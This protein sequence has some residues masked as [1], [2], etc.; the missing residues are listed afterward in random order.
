[1]INNLPTGRMQAIDTF[2]GLTVV[3]MLFFGTLYNNFDVPAWMSDVHT[4]S[5]T[6]TLADLI[7][8]AFLFVMGMAIP[9]SINR[10]I[11]SNENKWQIR[12]H[13]IGRTLALMVLG[14]FIANARHVD[15]W[16]TGMNKAVWPLLFFA[17]TLLILLDYKVKNNWLVRICRMIGI[18]GLIYLAVIFRGNDGWKAIVF[19]TKGPLGYLAWAYLYANII[20]ILTKGSG[21]GIFLMIAVSLGLSVL[22]QSSIAGFDWM[23][24]LQISNFAHTAIVLSGMLLSLFYFD[25]DVDLKGRKL[26]SRISGFVILVLIAAVLLNHFYGVSKFGAA[27]SWC[28][29]SIALCIVL[30][31]ILHWL[32]TMAPLSKGVAILQS[33]GATAL[34]AYFLPNIIFYIVQ[35]TGFTLPASSGPDATAII[36]SACFTIFSILIIKGLNKAKIRLYL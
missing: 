13:I 16:M 10:R 25:E 33:V 24:D 32:T 27:P 14:S 31:S 22:F 36:W 9:F 12:R 19:Y 3:M 4:T 2:R 29:Y 1:M 28:L 18:I 30:F 34:L 35:L 15:P 8:P 26:F 17:F 11:A 7:F 20:Y 6:L 23:S 5:L 21:N